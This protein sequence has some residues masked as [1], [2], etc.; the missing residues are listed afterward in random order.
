[1]EAVL[2]FPDPSNHPIELDLHVVGNFLIIAITNDVQDDIKQLIF[3][4]IY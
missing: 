4:V 3:D 1:M 2:K